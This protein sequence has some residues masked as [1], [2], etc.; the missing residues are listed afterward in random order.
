MKNCIWI[1]GLAALLVA[2]FG[3]GPAAAHAPAPRGTADVAPATTSIAAR[4]AAC[5]E[6]KVAI[7]RKAV[8]GYGSGR[9]CLRLGQG[10]SSGSRVDPLYS[11]V[12]SEVI[13]T[14]AEHTARDRVEEVTVVCWGRRD[15]QKIADAGILGY[16]YMG[17]RV[18]NLAPNVCRDLD[19]IA[20]EAERPTGYIAAAAVDTLAHEAIHVA[21]IR[22]EARAECYAMQLTRLTSEELGTDGIYGAALIRTLWDGYEEY[23]AANPEY[24]S[25]EC[26]NGGSL[27]LNPDDPY[28]WP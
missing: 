5:A 6:G 4:S 13:E 2:A 1:S 25:A 21:G 10:P 15:W 23:G 26:R 22:N 17:N 3:A 16:V 19:R 9:I 14:L 7:A 27:D 18:V 8:V 24:Y 28:F 11:R 12:A 20:Y